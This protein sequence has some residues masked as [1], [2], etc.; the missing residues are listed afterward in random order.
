MGYRLLHEA[1]DIYGEDRRFVLEALD[2]YDASDGLRVTVRAT[3][4]PDRERGREDYVGADLPGRLAD[5]QP[6]H[7]MS[8]PSA[9]GRA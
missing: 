8:S 9:A 5:L 6:Q 1:L 3:A 7:V 4:W 2:R